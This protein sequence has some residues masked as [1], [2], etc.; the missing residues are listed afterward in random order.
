L[1]S[2]LETVTSGKEE[3]GEDAF[4]STRESMVGDLDGTGSE[5]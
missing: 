5:D 4:P 2:G 3:W 1:L